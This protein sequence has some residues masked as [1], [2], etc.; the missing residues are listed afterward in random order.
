M[1]HTTAKNVMRLSLLSLSLI[2]LLVGNACKKKVDP[3]AEEALRQ[4]RADSLAMVEAAR[5][6]SIS[7][8]ELLA[9]ELAAAEAA[10]EAEELAAVEAQ[11]MME[12][13]N[14]ALDA[15]LPVYFDFD[16]AN[17]REESRDSLDRYAG[18]LGRYEAVTL[19]L[20]GH[21]DENGSVE[22]N[23]ALGERRANV[24][25]DY[26]SRL[27]VDTARLKTVSFGKNKPAFVG[28]TEAAWQKNRR[29][30][31]RVTAR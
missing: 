25:R 12:E 21:C 14:A 11:R 22:Y 23:L 8:A 13:M 24:V 26:L 2:L 1:S 20:E 19:L 29:V 16:K 28:H 5:Q 30:E 10:R 31:F 4:A 3:A 6:D 18:I 15:M 27:G 9:E 17:L 7:A